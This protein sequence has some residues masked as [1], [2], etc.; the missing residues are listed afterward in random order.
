MILT[1]LVSQPERDGVIPWRTMPAVG[2]MSAE[3]GLQLWKRVSYDLDCMRHFVVS[4]LAVYI[5]HHQASFRLTRKSTAKL[6][7]IDAEK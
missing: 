7:F 5:P 2:T 3:H 4:R 6:P 1:P